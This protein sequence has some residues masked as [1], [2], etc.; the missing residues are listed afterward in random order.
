[1]SNI[2][3]FEP[4][5]KSGRAKAKP[6]TGASRARSRRAPRSRNVVGTF[7]PDMAEA[8]AFARQI[9]GLLRSRVNADS[10]TSEDS[11]RAIAKVQTMICALKLA[12]IDV[13]QDENRLLTAKIEALQGKLD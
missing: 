13:L 12:H 4:M 10:P 5:R 9:V 3:P 8:R 6:R 11:N 7:K 1:M 2:I